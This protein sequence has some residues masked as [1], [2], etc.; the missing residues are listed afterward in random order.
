MNQNIRFCATPDGV[1]LAYAVTGEGPPLVMSATWL[2]HLEHQWRSLAWRPWL[3]AFTAEHKVLRHDS[4]GCGLSDRNAGNLSFETWVRDLECVVEAA[5]FRRFALIGT[6]WGGPIAIE[7]AARHP[8]RVSHLVLY[9][10]YAQGRLRR[11]DA[12]KEAAKSR[13]LTD[14]TRLGWGQDDHDFVHVWASRFQPGGTREHL[15]SW[16]E[17]MRA[18]TCADTAIRLFQIAWNTDVRDAARKIKCP[19][20]IIHPERD[21]VSPVEQGRLLA[22]LIPDCRFVQLATENHMPLADEPAWLQLVAE[23]HR[24]LA[25]P[26]YA[27]VTSRKALPLD[28]L[29]PRERAVLE[30]IAKGLDN[31]EIAISLRLSEKTVR[32]HITRIFD[33]IG[34][35]HRYQAIVLARD[36]GLGGAIGS[37]ISADGG[38]LSRT[39]GS[40]PKQ[41][42]DFGLNTTGFARLRV[43]TGRA[44]RAPARRPR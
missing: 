23:M 11:P 20:L 1:R 44:S 3:D 39:L 30:A 4:R 18:A 21:V 28:E 14:V 29:T 36:A 24:F 27:G 10:S 40:T 13:L 37:S 33:K 9:G 42:R 22:S 12:V 31:A 43:G 41:R 34:V 8:E 19:V 2:T 15:C 32:N 38:H 7:Y 6:C 35:K 25:E 5:D 26:G 17:Q 16:S